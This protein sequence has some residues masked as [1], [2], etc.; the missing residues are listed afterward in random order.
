VLESDGSYRRPVL[1]KGAAVRNSQ[2]EFI[3]SALGVAKLRRKTKT[4]D[5]RTKDLQIATKPV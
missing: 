1:A 4:P 3:A 2:E 5:Q